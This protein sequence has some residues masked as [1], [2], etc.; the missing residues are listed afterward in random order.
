MM[1]IKV[2]HICMSSLTYIFKA[3]FIKMTVTAKPEIIKKYWNK[4]KNS[5]INNYLNKPHRHTF[6]GRNTMK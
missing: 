3:T 1:I 2:S 4:Y 5:L 6:Y